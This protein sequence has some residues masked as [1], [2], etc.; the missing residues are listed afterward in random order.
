MASLPTV[1][2]GKVI[3]IGEN[4][5]IWLSETKDGERT[6]EASVWTITYSP[7]G[8]GQALFIKSELTNN[9]WRIYSDNKEMVRWLQKTVQGMLNPETSD[10]NIPIID[11]GF[12]I[13]GDVRS[14]WK[15][16]IRSTQDE[17]I[18]TWN[19]L[20][21]PILVQDKE[22]CEPGRPYGVNVV[23]VPASSAE[24]LLNDKKAKGK[25]WPMDLNGTPFST[26]ALAFCEN[27]REE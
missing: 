11:S 27:W 4:P 25:I 18:M 9:E 17:I 23:M 5:F 12:S 14:S 15:Q 22:V 19:N 26:G 13:D 21:E 1:Q 16:I 10:Q 8:S 24:L 3:L 7:K 20:N 2:D 6:T